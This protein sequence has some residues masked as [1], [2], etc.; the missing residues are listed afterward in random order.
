MLLDRM[1]DLSAPYVIP[2]TADFFALAHDAPV[3][4]SDKFSVWRCIDLRYGPALAIGFPLIR[5]DEQ[6][7]ASFDIHGLQLGAVIG[8][9]V[10]AELSL[11]LWLMYYVGN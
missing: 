1:F 2:H 8:S 3:A 5:A 10:N 4:E 9:D 7:F 11:D 6:I